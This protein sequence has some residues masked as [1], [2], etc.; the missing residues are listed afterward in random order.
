[1]MI[2]NKYLS[3]R[4]LGL[5]QMSF[6]STQSSNFASELGRQSCWP[7]QSPNKSL[8]DVFCCSRDAVRRTVINFL[9][10]KHFISMLPLSQTQ[11]HRQKKEALWWVSALA[12]VWLRNNE[13]KCL[14]IGVSEFVWAFSSHY[15]AL[16]SIFPFARLLILKDKAFCLET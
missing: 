15:T 2:E 9:S 7:H 13:N 12:L 1:M 16:F 11:L 14:K 4:L 3:N 8:F 6:Y 5:Y 10:G